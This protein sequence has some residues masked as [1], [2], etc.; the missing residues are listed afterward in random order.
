MDY[1]T[2][3]LTNKQ[4]AKFLHLSEITLALGE[5]R[6]FSLAQIV[7][8]KIKTGK[9]ENGFTARE[10][11]RKHWS[12]LQS[13]EMIQDVLTLLVDYGYLKT[14]DSGDGRLEKIRP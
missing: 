13:G 6:I 4:A 14:I 10:M 11:K 12:G 5:N 3:Y 8:G 1:S 2:D 7:L 9:L